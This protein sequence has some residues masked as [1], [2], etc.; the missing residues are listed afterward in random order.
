[1]N[2]THVVMGPAHLLSTLGIFL[3]CENEVNEDTGCLHHPQSSF[4]LS[5][6]SRHHFLSDL[7]KWKRCRWINTNYF[8]VYSVHGGKTLPK[9]S[10]HTAALSDGVTDE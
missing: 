9:C 7:A 2:N 1:M 4:L 5:L 8:L 3:I 6:R 10:G